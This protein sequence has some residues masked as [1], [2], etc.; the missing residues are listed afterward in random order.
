MSVYSADILRHAA[1]PFGLGVLEDPTHQHQQRNPICG[2]RVTW[3]VRVEEDTIID[4]RH[5]TKGC[6]LCKASASLLF[7]SLGQTSLLVGL[8]QIQA[9]QTGIQQLTLGQ[10]VTLAQTNTQLFQ[11]ISSAPARRSCVL[12]PWETLGALIEALLK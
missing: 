1:N 7:T 6:A 12:L 4:C 11:G 9:F 5:Q 3:Q 8:S 10:T 2:D